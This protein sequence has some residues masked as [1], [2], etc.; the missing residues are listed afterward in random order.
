MKIREHLAKWL[1]LSESSPD[2][3]TRE[4]ADRQATRY[5]RRIE[6]KRSQQEAAQAEKPLPED[7]L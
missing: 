7:E 6:G 5:A 1:K 3:G 4:Y 2:R